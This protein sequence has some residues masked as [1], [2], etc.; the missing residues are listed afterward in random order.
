MTAR[1]S[2]G[3]GSLYFDKERKCWVGV[4]DLGTDPQTHKRVRRKVSGQT[5]TECK[6]KLDELRAAARTAGV[7]PRGDLTVAQVVRELLE[8]PPA[9]WRSPVT[10]A[11]CTKLGERAIGV[12]GTTKVTRLTVRQVEA[13]LGTMA[14]EGYAAA[15]ISRT[16]SVLRMALRRAQRDHGLSRN[17]ADLAD[18]P[19]APRRVSRSMTPDQVAKL[20]RLELTPWWRAWVTSAVMLGLRP[21]ELLG[22]TWEH[23]DFQAGVI[24]VRHSLKRL[25]GELALSDLKTQASRRTLRMPAP[26]IVALKAHR[27]AQAKDRLALGAAY[28][29]HG[30]VFCDEAGGPPSRF[31]VRYMFRKLCRQAGIPAYTLRE[32][33]HTFVSVLSDSGLPIEQIARAVGHVNPTVTRNVYLHQITDEITAAATA[34]DEISKHQE[35][36]S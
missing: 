7:V 16:R 35:G 4:A 30:L 14:A 29:D 34:W 23:L 36:Q 19:H 12:L 33:R 22:L 28:T 2:R 3:E 11:T 21:G 24:R 17:V 8:H 26:V 10:V 9:E 31:H 32:T 13:F 25:D 5:K 6:A 27:K 15:T 18:M 20:L 1:R